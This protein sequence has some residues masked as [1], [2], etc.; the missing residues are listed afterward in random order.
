[1]TDDNQ[2]KQGQNDAWI[3]HF[4][5]R[6]NVPF[7]SL[8]E[9]MQKEVRAYKN[10]LSESKHDIFD[11]IIGDIDIISS[12]DMRVVDTLRKIAKYE[13]TGVGGP[14]RKIY[15]DHING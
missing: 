4:I 15:L 6:I 12:K 11:F 9:G 13:R 3:L 7:N 1:M 14:L 2:I 5:V 8:S 10:I